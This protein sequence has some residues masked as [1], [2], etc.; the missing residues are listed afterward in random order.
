[1]PKASESTFFYL[2]L[3]ISMFPF[4]QNR[5]FYCLPTNLLPFDCFVAVKRLLSQVI[6]LIQFIDTFLF[7]FRAIIILYTFWKSFLIPYS[8]F[9]INLKK[10]QS[11][12]HR[13]SK[14][15]YRILYSPPTD[16]LAY[17]LASFQI[18]K[19]ESNRKLI[20]IK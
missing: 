11:M 12:F 16:D 3:S 13:N 2:V 20:I 19:H 8:P 5:N 1:M 9:V 4:I 17:P 7:S 6:H 15:A 14:P 18:S 10:N